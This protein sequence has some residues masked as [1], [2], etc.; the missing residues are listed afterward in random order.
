MLDAVFLLDLV[1]P[2]LTMCVR[3]ILSEHGLS[4]TI[5]AEHETILGNDTETESLAE[6][7]DREKT[8][9]LLDASFVTVFTERSPHQVTVVQVLLTR[10]LVEETNIIH[11]RSVQNIMKRDE[12]V[13]NKLFQ[14]VLSARW[15]WPALVPRC[16]LDNPEDT[17]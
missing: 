2:H 10:F 7:C 13:R 6:S 1:G 4:I 3:Q 14:E 12:D 11:D 15:W 17:K 8:D 9:V 5:A 16:V